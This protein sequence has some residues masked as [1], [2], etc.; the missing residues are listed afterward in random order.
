MRRHTQAQEVSR[1]SSMLNLQPAC[2]A[3]EYG[4]RIR[5]NQLPHTALELSP[6]ARLRQCSGP[7]CAGAGT[8]PTSEP[9]TG[10]SSAFWNTMLPSRLLRASQ[11]ISGRHLQR[12][13]GHDQVLLEQVHQPRPALHRIMAQ[14]ASQTAPQKYHAR[15]I[16]QPR[17]TSWLSYGPL[18]RAAGHA[19][20]LLGRA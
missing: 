7:P 11:V 18:R 5:R 10:A 12:A 16:R 15:K 13:A 3:I 8:A 9:L 20:A 6:R 14:A 2:A 4:K 19:F 17:C 1:A